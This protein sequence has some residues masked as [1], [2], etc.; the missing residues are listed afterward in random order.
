MLA[1]DLIIQYLVLIYTDNLMYRINYYT[2][3]NVHLYDLFLHKI[4]TQLNYILN[5]SKRAELDGEINTGLR[6]LLCI[7]PTLLQ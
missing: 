6:C 5:N 3:I 2:L 7:P 1:C 4:L